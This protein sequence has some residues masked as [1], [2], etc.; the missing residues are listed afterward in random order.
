M[1]KA[2]LLLTGNAIFD[3]VAD[4]PASG[5]VAVSGNRIIGVGKPGNE[6]EFIDES[7]KVID[8]QDKLIMPGF[9]DSHVH[10]VLAGMYRIYAN[11]ADAKS[12]DE[13]CEILKD[14]VAK[15]P[16]DSEWV[17]G[18]SWYHVFWDNKKLP[19]KASLDKYFPDTPVFLL[20]AEA[21]GGWVNSKALEIAGVT[22]DTPDPFGGNF[23]RDEFGEPTGFLNESAI[24]FV[25]KYAYAMTEE[26]EIRYIR[27]F[28]KQ[29]APIG[30]TSINDVMPYFHGNIGSVPTYA[31]V[32]ELGELTVRV[33]AAPNLLGDLDEVCRWRDLY[34]SEKITVH[35]L[36]QFLDGVAPTHTAL[37]L[38]D[39]S[40]AP[41]EKG[42]SLSDLEVIKKAVPEAH[43]RGLSVKLHS[44][45]DASARLALDYF[46][47]AINMY[48]KNECRH[49][50][51]HLEVVHP[52]DIP[53]VG[54]L[55]IIP[56]MQPEHLALTQTFA[57]SPYPVVLGPERSK[58]TWPNKS[59]LDSAGVIA[60][61]SD[62]PVVDN[63]PFLEIFRAVERVHND[64]EPKGGWNPEQ[65]LTMAEALRGYTYGSA[66]GARRENDLGTLEAG[67]LADIVVIDRNLFEISKPFEILDAKVIMT[68]M[69]GKIIFE[70][71][72]Y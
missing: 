65:K 35:L 15:N 18:F 29:A 23:E 7:T 55:G 64:G 43:K 3:A 68:I 52:D 17:L 69:D 40:D 67:K 13:A 51:E 11:L 9:H 48:G 32:E 45:G 38:E 57:E 26:Q 44:C 59:L 53:R 24:G 56:S 5:F 61:G 21:H 72:K 4:K 34:T 8:M 47:N 33:N 14:F 25:T 66:Y 20:N 41:G 62:C 46:E 2:D 63:N 1:K 27:E 71:S 49:A 60:I 6:A 28:L 36:K 31:K 37:M 58:T 19:T 39:Y 50:I 22:K 54:E 10:F 42:I 70:Q 30:I 16:P 12:E